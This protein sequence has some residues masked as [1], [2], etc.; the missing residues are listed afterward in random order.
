PLRKGDLFFLFTDGLT[1]AKNKKDEEYG[2]DNLFKFVGEQASGKPYKS[3]AELTNNIS[4][5]LDSFSGYMN[6][7]DDITFIIARYLRDEM[8]KT[9]NN[10]EME[11][12]KIKKIPDDP[13]NK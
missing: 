4:M 2:M 11:K 5:E 13:S 10:N 6:P 12:I 1:E 8:K 3:V 9:P 7:V